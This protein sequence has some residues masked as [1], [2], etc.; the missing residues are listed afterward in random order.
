MRRAVGWRG[1]AVGLST[2]VLALGGCAVSQGV[3]PGGSA[4]QPGTV[5]A[6]DL[7]ARYSKADGA[8]VRGMSTD[9]YLDPGRGIRAEVPTFASARHLTTATGVLRDRALRD[10]AWAGAREAKVNWQLVAA[11]NGVLGVLVTAQQSGGPAPIASSSTVWFDAGS[12]RVSSS[13][14]LIAADQWGSFKNAVAEVAGGL[15]PIRLSRALDDAP[16]PQGRGPALGFAANGDLVATFAAGSVADG[17][18]VLQVPGQAVR[19]LLSEFGRRALTASTNPGVFD[20][21]LPPPEPGAQ[22][23]PQPS[24]LNQIPR[25]ATTVGVDCARTTCVALTF[26]DGPGPSTHLVV[27]GLLAA[28]A[29]A[30]FFQLGGMLQAAPEAGRQVASAGNEIAGHTWSHPTMTQLSADRLAN[31]EIR[32]TAEEM[33]KVYG[34]APL[35]MRPPSGV[36]NKATD[37]VIGAAGESLV[38]WNVDT[39]DW[40]H[41]DTA[42]TVAEAVKGADK[43]GSIVLMHDI[44]PSTGAAVPELVTQLRARGVTLVTVGE[45]TLN[46]P[47]FLPGQAYCS[48]PQTG[49]PTSGCS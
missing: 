29:P 26:D 37:K 44:H 22:P 42:K 39:R 3:R 5:S 34:R 7:P 48:V 6:T 18:V 1:I 13:P 38:M 30:T 27:E 33:V 15:D 41:R 16:A 14:V 21:T 28:K 45:L 46:T 11:G 17:Q 43:P 31:A 47:G 24:A 4:P 23:A 40:Q 12:G 10:A 19:P 9:T 36:H 2:L 20:G 35:M 8:L 25:P 49:Q 32:R